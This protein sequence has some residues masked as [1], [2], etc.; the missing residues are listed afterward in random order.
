M[1]FFIELPVEIWDISSR[2]AADGIKTIESIR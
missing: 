1:Y 2:T